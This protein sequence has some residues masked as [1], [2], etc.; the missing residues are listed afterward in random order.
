MGGSRV[1]SVRPR[2]II[3]SQDGFG[4]GHMR[5]TNSITRKFLEARPDASVLLLSDSPLGQLFGVQ[6]NQDYLKLPSI[7]KT[8]SAWDP[9]NLSIPFDEVLVMREN[10]IRGALLYF[11]PH[12]FLV[13][14]MPH[15]AKGEL[16][17]VLR[18]IHDLGTGTQVVLGLR[19]ILDAPEVIKTRWHSEGAYKAIEKFYDQ[20]LIYGMQE[21]YDLARE[22]GLKQDVGSLINYSGYVC[23]PALPRYTARARSTS[24]ASYENGT[25]LILSM[26]G[27]GADAF[28]MMRTLL[29]AFP[30]VRAKIPCTMQVITGPFMPTEQRHELEKMASGLP[31]RIR[32]TVSDTL[33]Y[34]DAADLVVSMAG[35]N[36]SIEILRSGKPAILIPRAGPSAEQ[37][38][39][40]TLFAD[41]GWVRFME[42]N[43]VNADLLAQAILEDL[44]SGSNRRHENVSRPNLMGATSA[45]ETLL[46]LLPEEVHGEKRIWQPAIQA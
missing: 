39:R 17:P 12:I 19:D 26:A 35:Y 15:G 45:V 11:K 28:P 29:E 32:N 6:K 2:M 44:A 18:E 42:P 30:K 5:R 20:V 16:Y 13:D 33:S 36:S 9:V 40:A 21:V 37:R 43:E 4:L 24:L 3:Y 23:T 34:L 8:G 38:M 46:R 14:H 41:R 10:I 25:K 22:L 1:K 27:G 31:V 7:V